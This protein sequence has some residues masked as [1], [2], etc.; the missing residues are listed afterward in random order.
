[1][2]GKG[3]AVA[4]DPLAAGIAASEPR[5][6][7]GRVR[8]LPGGGPSPAGGDSDAV[9]VDTEGTG[10]VRPFPPGGPAKPGSPRQ[11]AAAARAGAE[12]ATR[13]AG[14]PPALQSAGAAPGA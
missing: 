4:A 1:H 3:E 5:R 13:T 11:S 10:G 6:G 8:T 9:G 7:G 14:R 2:G 12:T